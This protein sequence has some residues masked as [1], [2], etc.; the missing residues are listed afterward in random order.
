MSTRFKFDGEVVSDKKRI[1]EEF[2][3]FYVNVG[4]SLANKL[5]NSDICPTSF[6]RESNMLSMGIT[7]AVATEELF[8]IFR[9]LKDPSAGCDDIA[10]CIVKSTF[11][12]SIDILLHIFNLSILNGIFPDELKLAKVI[13]LFKSG[14]I[15][16]TN[17]YMPVSI[18][19]LFY[20]VLEKLMYDRL[21]SFF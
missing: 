8:Q 15:M 13:T 4:L 21:L 16:L 20:K 5:P 7:A 6:I 1:A 10:T 18:L 9:N 2:N 19:P 14:D 11:E 17:N 12:C 3:K